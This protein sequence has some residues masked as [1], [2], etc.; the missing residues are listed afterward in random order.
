MHTSAALHT[1]AAHPRLHFGLVGLALALV[2]A[3][4]ASADWV[5]KIESAHNK[6]T[7][8]Q[9]GALTADLVVE[10]GGSTLIDGRLVMD[11]P[12]GKTRIELTGGEHAGS[13]M[14]F[15]GSEA[16]LAPADSA[17]RGARFHVLTWSYFLAAPMK[18]SDAGTHVQPQG[19][20]PFLD[21]TKL[22]AAKL[23]FGDGVG[24]SPDD[25]YLLYRDRDTKR[26]AGMAYIVTFGK[27][28]E[29]AEEE[30]H[31][32]VYSGWEEVNGVWLSTEWTFYDWTR[33]KGV[34]GDPV[35][36]VKLRNL[37]FVQFSAD[38]FKAPEGAKAQPAPPAG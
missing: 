38:A 28:Q 33:E 15:D 21:G 20:L 5:G 22:A 3:L 13:V 16:W 26:L 9:Q 19:E 37:R 11:T 6:E 14:G 36:H 24:D 30:P 34:F 10:F 12:G 7:Y 1:S 31:A 29:K 32:I 35:G 17:F 23:T 2:A 18:L 27:S 25:W 4:P 8:S